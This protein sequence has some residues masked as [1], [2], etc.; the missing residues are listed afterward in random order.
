LQTIP[1]LHP[2]GVLRTTRFV[3]DESVAGVTRWNDELVTFRTCIAPFYCYADDTQADPPWSARSETVEFVSLE[4]LHHS[5]LP[6]DEVLC[7]NL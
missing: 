7:I 1:G 5:F 6:W 3:P 4:F 2:Q